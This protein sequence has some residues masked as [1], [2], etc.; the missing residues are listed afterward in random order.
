MANTGPL[1]QPVQLHIPLIPHMPHIP[2]LLEKQGI[3]LDR[4]EPIDTA[5][6]F[7]EI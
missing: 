5:R 4:P 2:R 7:A 3:T 6:E 1:F